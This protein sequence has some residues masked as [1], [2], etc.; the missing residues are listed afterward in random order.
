VHSVV[1]YT[2][3]VKSVSPK[4]ILKLVRR[5]LPSNTTYNKNKF[6][7]QVSTLGGVIIRRLHSNDDV[8]IKQYIAKGLHMSMIQGLQM[9]FICSLHGNVPGLV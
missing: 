5:L 1:Y 3:T 4:K 8:S 6:V 2:L 9:L 7:L